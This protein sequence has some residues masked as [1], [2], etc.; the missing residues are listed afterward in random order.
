M[1]IIKTENETTEHGEFKVQTQ[2]NGIKV[3]ILKKPSASYKA[4][5]E[6][7]AEAEKARQVIEDERLARERLI[8]ERMRDIAIKQLEDEGKI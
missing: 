4:K 5:M 6:K 3:R 7:R 1:K 2:S 8:K